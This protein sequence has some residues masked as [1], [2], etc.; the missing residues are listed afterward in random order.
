MLVIVV[1]MVIT[2]AVWATVTFGRRQ[3]TIVTVAGPVGC[4]TLIQLYT[5]TTTVSKTASL[6]VVLK[7]K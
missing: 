2:T 6:F 5:G 7:E 1:I 4:I 3:R